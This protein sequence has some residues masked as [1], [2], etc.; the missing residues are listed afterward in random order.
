MRGQ[1]NVEQ[2]L[3]GKKSCVR[4]ITESVRRRR[5]PPGTQNIL[6]LD[7]GSEGL[8]IRLHCRGGNYY[9]HI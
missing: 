4:C 3:T 2:T 5:V 6:I 7:A 1:K 9:L 8:G